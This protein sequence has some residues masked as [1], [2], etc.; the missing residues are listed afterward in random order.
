V[1]DA[2]TFPRI[3]E[4]I[5]ILRQASVARFAAVS[6]GDYDPIRAMLRR[7]GQLAL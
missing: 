6:D 5:P 7:A 4:R 3:I 1:D 2:Q